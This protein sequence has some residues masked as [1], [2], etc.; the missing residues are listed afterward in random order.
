V[1]GLRNP[2]VF[3]LALSGLIALCVGASTLRRALIQTWFRDARPADAPT[4]AQPSDVA[5]VSAAP[6]GPDGNQLRPVP[7]VRVL[8][9]DG[10]SAST[11]AGLPVLSRFCGAGADLAVDVGFPTV[12]LP[13]QAVLW[14]GLTQQQLGLLYRI[15]PL[16]Q[17]PATAA[18]AR[19]PGSAAVAEDQAFIAGSFGF[20]SVVPATNVTPA[21]NVSAI[22]PTG[23]SEDTFTQAALDLAAGPAPLGFIH[24]LRIDK[25]GHKAGA[26]SPQYAQ[27]AAWAD[28]L[29]GRLL[30]AAPPD[31]DMR[32]FVL[33]DH[34][35]RARGGHG[36]AEDEL[37]IVRGCIAGG[38]GPTGIGG[39]IHLVDFSRALFD[40]L[41]LSPNAGGVGRPL[42]FALAHPDPG[43]T[44]AEGQRRGQRGLLA[45]ALCT[46][47]FAGIGF[48]TLR[49]SLV[50]RLTALEAASIAWLPTACAAIWFG[51]GSPTLS[52]PII[53]PPQ[54]RDIVVAGAP[55]LLLL[56]LLVLLAGRKGHDK[57]LRLGV[58]ALLPAIVAA[59]AS[60]VACGGVAALVFAGQGPPLLEPVTGLTSVLLALLAAASA[61]I[62]V[63]S[64]MRALGAA[65]AH[66]RTRRTVAKSL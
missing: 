28:Q 64:A 35:Q 55:G 34:G 8:L 37:R 50:L 1:P 46:F 45:I 2:R 3:L 40:S 11:A 19:A 42:A 13:V 32:W 5:S 65:V 39:R 23:W 58:I 24:V 56:G 62:A 30:G 52:N 33:S 15:K 49:R 25:A 7:H 29:L 53:Y 48:L 20:A 18:P 43:A 54:G 4:L 51:T 44:I 6:S 66:R 22:V 9:L 17:A 21:G 12:S 38:G 36:G 47:A 59:V 27:A 63:L 60:L 31:A 61:G 26:A 10:L 41:A 16:P 14:T 57:A